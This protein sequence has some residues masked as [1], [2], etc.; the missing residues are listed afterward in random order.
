LLLLAC[1]GHGWVRGEVGVRVRRACGVRG[2]GPKD[3]AQRREGGAW[4][5]VGVG[6]RLGKGIGIGI[7]IGIGPGLGLGLGLGPG[8]GLG[9]E[10]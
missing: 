10:G 2:V 7:G 4:L 9:L 5:G 8:L 6:L 3:V 1:M